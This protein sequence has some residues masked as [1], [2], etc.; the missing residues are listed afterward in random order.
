MYGSPA[1]D[2]SGNI[3]DYVAEI[4]DMVTEED[5]EME[6]K[7]VVILKDVDDKVAEEVVEII[8]KMTK[9]EADKQGGMCV[10]YVLTTFSFTPCSLLVLYFVILHVIWLTILF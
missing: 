7:E 8:G 6:E 9:E 5:E 2:V 1:P 4:M 10:L 3:D